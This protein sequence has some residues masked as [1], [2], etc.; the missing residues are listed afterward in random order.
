M[1]TIQELWQKNSVFNE[2]WKHAIIKDVFTPNILQ[3][4]LDN[5][6]SDSVKPTENY[7]PYGTVYAVGKDDCVSS[8]F[9][10]NLTSFFN[11][12][13][14]LEYVENILCIPIKLTKAYISV[15]KD[16]AGQQLGPHM[17]G[18]YT[19]HIY[20]TPT[21]QSFT[22][23][24]EYYKK[25][26]N[27]DRHNSEFYENTKHGICYDTNFCINDEIEFLKQVIQYHIKKH[28]LVCRKRPCLSNTRPRKCAHQCA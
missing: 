4:I 13:D 10:Y 8:K 15:H 27:L 12:A 21:V 14:V 1:K 22:S 9:W 3:L 18:A 11:S 25:G 23:G 7:E 5:L 19:F 16:Y 26:T 28:E 2:P 20:L 24:T 17:D 6:P